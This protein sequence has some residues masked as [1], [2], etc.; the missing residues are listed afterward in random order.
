M[1]CVG[2]DLAARHSAAVAV[3]ETGTVILESTLDTGPAE[4]PPNPFPKA[5]V[6]AEWWVPFLSGCRSVEASHDGLYF[7]IEDIPPHGMVDPKPAL[8]LQGALV[9][10]MVLDQI[11]CHVIY[12]K[13]WQDYFG[14]SKK[15]HGNSKAWAKDLAITLKYT[16]GM[17]WAEGTKTL[18]K[19]REDLTDARALAEWL[20]LQI[21]G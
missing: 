16:P 20:R 15:A 11:E 4:K 10:F 6:L 3:D 2:I 13:T 19:Q 12:A 5:R 14:Y 8:K 21:T 18:A 7:V 9:A 1:L 17:T